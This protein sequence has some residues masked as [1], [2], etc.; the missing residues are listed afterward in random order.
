MFTL[1]VSP[2]LEIPDRWFLVPISITRDGVLSL[3]TVWGKSK[4]DAEDKAQQRAAAIRLEYNQQSHIIPPRVWAPAKPCTV[5]TAS[6][7]FE[8]LKRL[9]LRLEEV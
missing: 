3:E 5:Q 8:S 7:W 2:T 9:N 6:E 4:E 1:E